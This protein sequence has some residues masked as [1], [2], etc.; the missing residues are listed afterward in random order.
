MKIIDLTHTIEE[1]MTT[2]N[3]YWH[4]LVQINQ[5]GRIGQEGRETRKISMGTHTGTHIDA[6]LHFVE[7]GKGIDQIS[8]DRLFGPVKI[9]DFSNVPKAYGITVKDLKKN[10]LGERML[11]RFNWCKYWG[12]KNFYKDYPYFEEEAAQYLV[13]N[14]VKLIGID[15]PSPD[16]GRIMLDSNSYGTEIDSPVHKIFLKN[17]V[18]LVEY[19]A[20]LEMADCKLEWNIAVMPLKVK[21]ADGAP[22]RVCIWR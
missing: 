12:T 11:F 16:D 2:F 7:S 20:N 3:A 9:V 4:P 5:I 18:L 22:A 8:L 21:N 13:D 19:L 1:G 15:T 14:N 17:E 6:P 10:S